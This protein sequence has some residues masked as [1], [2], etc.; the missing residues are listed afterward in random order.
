MLGLSWSGPQM[1]SH[2]S[3][4]SHKPGCRKPPHG[5]TTL[6]SAGHGLLPCE[7]GGPPGQHEQGHWVCHRLASHS[8][9]PSA[10]QGEDLHIKRPASPSRHW[11]LVARHLLGGAG[12]PLFSQ[13]NPMVR[14]LTGSGA[15]RLGD[16]THDLQ[17]E[18]WSS[19]SPHEGRWVLAN[20]WISHWAMRS[21]V[22]VLMEK[23]MRMLVW[24]GSAREGG[25]GGI[26][27][28]G[29][30]PNC[31][32]K[33]LLS[34]CGPSAQAQGASLEAAGVVV[35]GHWARHTC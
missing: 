26:H 21:W 17:P 8:W 12:P 16:V 33:A 7:G 13:L 1:A 14:V 29:S 23:R 4:W 6:A 18:H 30:L 15:P 24:S 10:L 19:D 22:L 3:Q 11:S 34:H 25:E 9:A 5:Q 2:R 20:Q 27:G 35:L 28:Q 31:Q 32:G